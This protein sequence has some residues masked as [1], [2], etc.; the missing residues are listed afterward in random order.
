M[1]IY[2]ISHL[3]QVWWTKKGNF[4]NRWGLINW[5][6]K[7]KK[8]WGRD[9]KG[10]QTD[11]AEGAALHTP[12]L[13]KIFLKPQGALLGSSQQP[14]HSEHLW[15]QIPVYCVPLTQPG[16]FSLPGSTTRQWDQL[17]PGTPGRIH[18]RIRNSHSLF[19]SVGFAFDSTD[20]YQPCIGYYGNEAFLH[21]INP[22]F[23]FL[24]RWAK[25]F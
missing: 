9:F 5:G 13:S 16:A 3:P 21:S 4:K 7:Q 2:Q 6:G 22:K 15:V 14:R 20:Q 19:L 23:L 25:Y 8:K 1:L 18:M 12:C 11:C 17:P 24:Q 10:L